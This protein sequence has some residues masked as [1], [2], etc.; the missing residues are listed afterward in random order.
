[1]ALCKHHGRVK[2]DNREATRN[3]KDHLDDVLADR[4]LRIVELRGIVPGEGGA[5]VAVVDEAGSAVG[6]V[7]QAED[8]GCV[9]LIEVVVLDLDLD[10]VVG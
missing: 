4:M 7:A 6:V 5:V 2:T 3:L 8:D 1:M 9:G 10:A